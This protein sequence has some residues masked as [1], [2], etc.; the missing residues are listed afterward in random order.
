M[1]LSLVVELPE[2]TEV[3]V[4]AQIGAI[5]RRLAAGEGVEVACTGLDVM[6][7]LASITFGGPDPEQRTP[8][9]SWW[10]RSRTSKPKDPIAART[11]SGKGWG[12]PTPMTPPSARKGTLIPAG[13]EAESSAIAMEEVQVG[14]AQTSAA[15]SSTSEAA[16]LAQFVGAREEVAVKHAATEKEKKQ[17]RPKRPPKAATPKKAPDAPAPAPS[18]A[19]AKARAPSPARAPA[20]SKVKASPKAK[21][22][23]GPAAAKATR[24]KSGAGTAAALP[25]S[26]DGSQRISVSHEQ[27][28]SL[29]DRY[30]ESEDEEDIAEDEVSGEGGSTAAAASEPPPPRPAPA[31]APSRGSW[32]PLYGGS[33]NGGITA[34]ASALAA[35]VASVAAAPSKRRANWPSQ[36]ASRAGADEPAPSVALADAPAPAGSHYGGRPL[37]WDD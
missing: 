22:G 25:A 36:A 27:R 6:L 15:S 16:S 9:G 18:A 2:D 19:A 17:A 31:P 23:F 21:G 28:K 4:D 24:N 26:P 32:N 8:R 34:S 29:M 37:R 33:P 5:A 14:S 35:E 12:T 3:P 13:D 30:F 20:S 7:S 11:P 1:R 10:R